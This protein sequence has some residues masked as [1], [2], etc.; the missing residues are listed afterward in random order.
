MQLDPEVN[1]RKY[2]Q[3]VRKLVDQRAALEARGIFLL[4]STNFP[5]VELVYVPRH[6][7][8]VPVPGMV[9]P[10]GL[11]LPPGAVVV[12]ELP[13]LAAQAFKARFDLTDFDLRAPSLEFRNAW[14]DEPL[15]YP[16]MF[17]ALEFE[18]ERKSHCVLLDDHPITH[19]PFLCLRGIREYHEH[20]QHTGDDWLLYRDKMSLFSIVMSV[21]RVSIDLVHPQLAFMPNAI[22][23]V[24][25]GEEKA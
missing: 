9:A 25:V 24:F 10:P 8:S 17:R 2:E 11:N 7:L 15:S 23:V 21:W 12:A 22:G 18:A 20:P 4:S 13:S 3:E 16:Q 6:P 5:L 1:R 19:K 14:T